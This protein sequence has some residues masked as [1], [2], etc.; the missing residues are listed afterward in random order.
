MHPENEILQAE[1]RL[2][3]ALTTLLHGDAAPL[4][5]LL[6]RRD[7][8]TAFLG[9]GGHERG[10]DALDARWDWATA[11]FTAMRAA[12]R[13]LL[14]R[15]VEHLSIVVGAD[16]G[17]ATSLER[18]TFSTPNGPPDEQRLRITHIYRR[19]DGAWKLV[20]RHVDRLTERREPA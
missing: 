12:G 10:W 17:Y 3:D 13:Q 14:G 2:N 18:S 1:T 9:W 19:E 15:Q 4:K 20:H 6:S 8:A 7:N 5:A 11:R 16:L